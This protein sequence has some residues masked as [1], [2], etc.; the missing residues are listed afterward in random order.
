[1]S[2][3]TILKAGI[4]G[5][6]LM[7]RWHANALKNSGACLKAV[8]DPDLKRAKLLAVKHVN[9]EPFSDIEPML[10]KGDLDVLHICTPL[11]THKNIAERAIRAGINLIIEKPLTPTALEAEYL[12]DLAE[13]H[14]VLICPVHQFIFQ[15]GARKA[16]KGLSGIGRLIYIKGTF[17]SAGASGEPLERM[18]AIVQDILPH[19][20]S[21]MQAFLPKGISQAEWTALRPG[22]GELLAIG[23]I[24]GVSL[25][26]FISLNARPTECSLLVA[27]TEG[28]IHIDMFHGFSFIESG[29]V[30]RI[31]KIIRPFSLAIQMFSA[32]A[33]NLS[34][35]VI[36]GEFAYPGLR[37]LIDSF[38]AAVRCNADSPISKTDTIA[39]AQARDILARPGFGGGYP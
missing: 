13:E 31:R 35:R 33:L 36:Q 24:N 27:G 7:G 37:Q 2:D 29:R 5:A 20:L 34:R 21:L 8:V 15:N 22:D 10:N 32:A 23:G 17:C 28:T 3:K 25:S 38:Y 26:V 39:V 14:D 16:L 9:A 19:P 6:G 4:I 11:S 1:M 18:D 12:F 30:S